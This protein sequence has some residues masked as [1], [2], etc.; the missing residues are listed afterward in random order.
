M[1]GSG[2]L[3]AAP[4]R[5]AGHQKIPVRCAKRNVASGTV[6]F[7]YWHFPKNL[8]PYR[9][10]GEDFVLLPA[11]FDDLFDWNKHGKL[12]PVMA[13]RIPTPA[14]GGVRDGGKTVV[15]HLRVGLRWSNGSQITS[16]NIK[17]GWRVDK[18]PASGPNCLGT[19]DIIH[20]VS[21]PGPYT[22]VFHLNRPFAPFAAEALPTLWPTSWPGGWKRGDAKAAARKI[23]Q[24]KS[25]NFLSPKYPT[26]GPYQVAKVI[27]GKS[28]QLRPMPFYSTLTCGASIAHL[29]MRYVPDETNVFGTVVTGKTDFTYA[30]PT[31]LGLVQQHIG[32]LHLN[33]Q[34]ALDVEHLQLNHTANYRGKPNPL[35]SKKVRLAL[36]L[37][38][39]KL[40]LIED[41]RAVDAATAKRLEASTFLVPRGPFHQPFSDASLN[42]QWDPIARTYVEPG[43]NRAVADARTLLRSTRWPNGF[44]I[45]LV[46]NQNFHV[47]RGVT[48]DELESSWRAIGVTVQRQVV[49][50]NRLFGSSASNGHGLA[51]DHNFQAA[52]FSIFTDPD[53][54]EF[55]VDLQGNRDPATARG[56][57]ANTNNENY[58]GVHN[59][60]IDAAFKRGEASYNPAIR[61][62]AYRA[63]QVQVNKDADWIPLYYHPFVSID[64]GRIAHFSISSSTIARWALR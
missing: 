40:K 32:T 16:A 36:A 34:P 11:M 59:R 30:P 17:F 28:I 46:T 62:R 19:C 51:P 21:T 27:P 9:Y 49:S 22:A 18:L 7:P 56:G 2:L 64:D 39:D 3:S 23:G 42:G 8:S 52:L 54:S 13:S 15:I 63:I 1:V 55:H 5:A 26:N 37:S 61:K 47:F 33:I 38:V 12:V 57:V 4:V 41:S 43:S 53:P 58:A 50:E 24:D 6:S 31:D 10:S 14:N 20:S 35:S 25:F 48:M 44:T 29:I 45:N 60:V